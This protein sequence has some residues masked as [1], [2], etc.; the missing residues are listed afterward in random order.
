MDETPLFRGVRGMGP[1]LMMPWSSCKLKTKKRSLPAG[2]SCPSATRLYLLI[3]NYICSLLHCS[4]NGSKNT[5]TALL[6]YLI[7]VTDNFRGK[8]PIIFF[9]G[10]TAPPCP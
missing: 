9:T 3:Y 1:R 6:E 4:S 8:P 5:M 7:T 2:N 10:T